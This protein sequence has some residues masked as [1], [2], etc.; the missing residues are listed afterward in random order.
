MNYQ[1]ERLKI[2][3]AQRCAAAT[4]TQL[5]DWST[6]FQHDEL[7]APIIAAELESR[8]FVARFVGTSTS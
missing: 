8:C 5:Q 1:I 4:D 3:L 7:F 2:M 6:K